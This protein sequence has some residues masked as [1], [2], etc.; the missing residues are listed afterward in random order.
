[1][2]LAKESD[3]ILILEEIYGGVRKEATRAE[4]DDKKTR[5]KGAWAELAL[6][7]NSN[8]WNPTND[9][10]DSRVAMLD[11][12][13]APTKP[14][15]PEEVR[16]IF[17]DNRTKYTRFYSNYHQSGNIEE[18]KAGEGDEIFFNNFVKGN[19]VFYYMH[20]LLKL[21]VPSVNIAAAVSPL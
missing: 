13:H 8:D 10:D 18:G 20:L 14:F 1:M 15:S 9:E 2:H 11:P 4:I 12:S 5:T 3:S 7:F 19:L 21:P 16:A 17:S 6:K